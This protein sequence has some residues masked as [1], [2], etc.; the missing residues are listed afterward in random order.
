MARRRGRADLPRMD[1]GT[2]RKEPRMNSGRS[3]RTRVLIG[4]AFAIVV[5]A[6]GI[7]IVRAPRP[8][9]RPVLGS[10]P[11]FVLE[12]EQERSTGLPDLRGAVWVAGFISTRCTG[13]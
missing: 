7:A 3:S 4:V 13:P 10:L 2:H 9:P 5:V 6:A 11:G 8:S 12:D 1:P